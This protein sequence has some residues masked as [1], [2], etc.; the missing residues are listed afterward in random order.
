MLICSKGEQKYQGKVDDSLKSKGS[1]IHS[2]SL[3]RG[4][5]KCVL[6][7]VYTNFSH[8]CTRTSA[9]G[10]LSAS[11]PGCT[12][13]GQGGLRSPPGVSCSRYLSYNVSCV[14]TH[15]SECDTR[16]STRVPGYNTRYRTPSY[17]TVLY[18]MTTWRGMRFGRYKL[19]KMSNTIYRTHCKS[20][21]VW[22]AGTGTGTRYRYR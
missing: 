10:W 15:P 2:F 9:S 4:T 22:F 17:F 20:Y 7:L 14:F 1:N 11:P 5:V 8:S 18:G 16:S 6:N 3:T 12:Q 13:S 19:I 21:R